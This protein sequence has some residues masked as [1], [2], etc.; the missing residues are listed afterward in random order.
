MG[1]SKMQYKPGILVYLVVLSATFFHASNEFAFA[2][3][4]NET[5]DPDSGKRISFILEMVR[6]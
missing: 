5:L 6:L 4:T 1:C 3:D 2:E